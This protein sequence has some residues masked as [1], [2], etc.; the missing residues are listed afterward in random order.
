M[1]HSVLLAHR[2]ALSGGR[3]PLFT[4]VTAVGAAAAGLLLVPTAAGGTAYF[5][6][7]GNFATAGDQHDFYFDLTRPVGSAEVLRF[8]TFANGGGVNAAGDTIPAGG[9]DSV[10]ELFDSAAAQRGRDDDGSFTPGFDSLLSWP[11][12]A[13]SDLVPLNTDPL[14]ADTYRLNLMEYQNN[15]PGAWALDLVGPA[16]AIVVRGD[17]YTGSSTISSLTAGNGAQINFNGGYEL[18]GG[19]AFTF[20]SGADFTVAWFLDIGNSTYGLLRLEGPGTTLTTNTASPTWLDW[21]A[22]GGIAEIYLNDGATANIGAT[23][24][25]LAAD[26]NPNSYA[27]LDVFGGADFTANTLFVGTGSGEALVQVIESGSTFTQNGAATLTVGKLLVDPVRSDRLGIV[28]QAVF[29]SGTGA[30]TVNQNGVIYVHA[31]TFNANGALTVASTRSAGGHGIELTS[32]TSQGRINSVD[33]TVGT[34]VASGSVLI[35]G[36]TLEGSTPAKWEVSGSMRIGS[37]GFGSGSATVED[38]GRLNISNNLNVSGSMDA[39][40]TLTVQTGGEV[41]VGNQFTVGSHGTVNLLGSTITA[42]SFVVQPGGTFTHEDGTLTVDGGAFDPGTGTS[43]YVITGAASSD[44]PK[45]VLTSG[46]DANLAGLVIVGKDNWGELTVENGAT[47]SATNMW[48][49]NAP[50]SPASGKVTVQGAN[51][52]LIVTASEL[53]FHSLEVGRTG[54]GELKISAGGQVSVQQGGV[55]LGCCLS[56]GGNGSGEITVEGQDSQLEA[57]CINFRAV[58]GNSHVTVRDRGVI[59]ATDSGSEIWSASHSSATEIEVEV[60]DTGSLLQVDGTFLSIKGGGIH[61]GTARLS[62]RNGG[63]AHAAGAVYLYGDAPGSAYVNVDG[64]AAGTA[65]FQVDGSLYVGGW[66]MGAIPGTAKV[67]VVDDGQVVAG[68][69][70]VW[71][72]G[73]IELDSGGVI[74]TSTLELGGGRLQGNGTVQV[75]DSLTNSGVV[76]PGLSPGEITVSGGNYVQDA[77]G[78]LLIE[79]GG[80]FSSHYDQLSIVS[81]SATLAGALEVSLINLGS[82]VFSPGTGDTLEILSAAAGLGGTTFTNELLPALA[83][84]LFLDVRYDPTAVVLEVLGVLGDYN[85][86]GTVNAADYTV[87]R[88]MLGQRGIGL[89]A[90]GSGPLGVPDGVIDRLD[91][92]FW[93][94]HYGATGPGSGGGIKANVPEPTTIFLVAMAV[95]GICAARAPRAWRHRLLAAPGG[96]FRPPH[97][98]RNLP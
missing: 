96:L 82:G 14:P 21:G 9:I 45:V 94:A 40:A 27:V 44:R 25:N 61:T 53:A 54:P 19:K 47:L 26:T 37:A 80:R 71:E 98:W 15:D 1:K 33:V 8:E 31:A 73:T 70:K 35:N 32:L 12:V 77:S 29:N 48:T 93:K 51:S 95:A 56:G 87:W 55:S 42:G 46:A 23:H 24:I 6:L 22:D 89:A 28:D 68:S 76:A 43:D 18:N 67:T 13:Q 39:T 85:R 38:R 2:H 62:I 97:S 72:P 36:A 16:D 88:N 63:V 91:F 69:V 90:D 52:R 49:S 50:M 79:I 7:V 86:D 57:K 11:G 30:I 20:E 41:T 75:S 34:N 92:D 84:G 65:S 74:S 4:V 17:N 66:E 64:G 81:G 60:T 83:G 78:R 3:L 10:L 59:H 5:S 58:G